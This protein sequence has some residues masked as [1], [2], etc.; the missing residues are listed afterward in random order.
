VQVLHDFLGFNPDFLPRHAR[1]FADV[2][3]VAT[4]AVSTYIEEVKS[5][6]FPS[7]KESF[8]LEKARNTANYIAERDARVREREERGE[9]DAT[10]YGSR[11]R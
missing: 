3:A 11:A 7:A 1:R 10:P 4:E 2:A 9:P 5:G 8:G 6:V